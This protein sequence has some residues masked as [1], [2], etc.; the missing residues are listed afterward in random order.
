MAEDKS[1]LVR[2]I[3]FGDIIITAFITWIVEKFLDFVWQR[4]KARIRLDGEISDDEFERVSNRVYAILF[5]PLVEAMV[6]QTIA[7]APKRKSVSYSSLI[8]RVLFLHKTYHKYIGNRPC[9]ACSRINL[10]KK[11]LKKH[12]PEPDLYPPFHN[13]SK[14]SL[15]DLSFDLWRKRAEAFEK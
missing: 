10:Y 1:K 12:V 5:L 2:M 8:R 15:V 9:R 4:G 7:Q 3:S 11:N 6:A 14:A 13:F